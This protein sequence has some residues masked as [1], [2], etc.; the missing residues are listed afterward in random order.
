MKRKKQVK[1]GRENLRGEA[2]LDGI[3]PRRGFWLVCNVQRRVYGRILRTRC[4][5]TIVTTGSFGG[6]CDHAPGH[7]YGRNGYGYAETMPVGEGW[8]YM[9]D[10][11]WTDD[12]PAD[13]PKVRKANGDFVVLGRLAPNDWPK[14]RGSD[15]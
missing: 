3:A 5:G 9:V 7:L 11:A 1:T 10:L 12:P 2:V 8:S 14:L 15:A 6:T 4:N 13:W